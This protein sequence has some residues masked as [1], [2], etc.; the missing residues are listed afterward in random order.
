MPILAHAG[1]LLTWDLAAHLGV[2]FFW[3]AVAF[4][5]LVLGSRRLSKM[6]A[7]SGA[8]IL[9]VAIAV[10][11]LMLPVPSTLSDDIQRYLW[12]GKVATAGISPYL[13]EPNAPAV[14]GLRDESWERLPHRQVPTVYPPLALALFSVAAHLPAPVFALKLLLTLFDLVTCVLLLILARIVGLPT[15]RVVWYAWNPLVSLEVAG[16]G[17]VDALGV[18][19]MVLLVVCLSQHPKRVP[20]AALAAVAGVLA[21]LIPVVGFPVW[22]R[23]SGR[24]LLFLS[25][26]VGVSVMALVPVVVS[27]GGIP[28]GLVTFGIRW[29]FNG[30]LFEPLWRLA[31]SLDVPSAAS[32]LLDWLKVQTGAHDFFNHFY[33]LNYPQLWAKLVLGITLLG[34]IAVAVLRQPPLAGMQW[35]FGSV[36]LCSAT[37]YPWYLLWILPWAALF[38]NRAWLLASATVILSYIPQFTEVSLFPWI[39]LAVWLPPFVVWTR[40]RWFSD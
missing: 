24:P 5:G 9:A 30:P 23:Q 18:T 25:L 29:E 11:L 8:L 21:K 38:G 28:E 35:I 10:R 22:A 4:L 13:H 12:D 14:S 27:T 37:V 34:A 2:A 39:Y 19:C 3:L 33:P 40:H 32:G 17:H 20:G 16:M 26:A 7:P 1:L 31:D 36:I 6:K 15:Q